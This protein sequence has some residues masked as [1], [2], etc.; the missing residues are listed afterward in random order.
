MKVDSFMLLF[1]VLIFIFFF[2]VETFLTVVLLLSKGYISYLII[3]L[4][5][6]VSYKM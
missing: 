2:T 3:A 4:Y 5:T 1:E 6:V